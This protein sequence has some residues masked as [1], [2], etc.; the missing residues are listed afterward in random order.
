MSKEKKS[1]KDV[2]ASRKSCNAA[3]T[4]LSHYILMDKKKK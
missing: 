4:G 1:K 3:G 2:I